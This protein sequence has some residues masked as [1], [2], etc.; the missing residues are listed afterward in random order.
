MKCRY[1]KYETVKHSGWIKTAPITPG[2]IYEIL[3]ETTTWND[4]PAYIVEPDQISSYD[5]YWSKKDPKYF[6][7]YTSLFEEPTEDEIKQYLRDKKIKEIL[8]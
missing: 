3:G 1:N 8:K 4:S 2:K 7:Y 5:E 6:A